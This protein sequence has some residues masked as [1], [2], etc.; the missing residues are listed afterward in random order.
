MSNYT[1]RAC[2]HHKISEIS[3]IYD[4]MFY[5][6]LYCS[7]H[8]ADF[9]SFFTPDFPLYIEKLAFYRIR[10]DTESMRAFHGGVTFFSRSK[11]EQS[12]SELRFTSSLLK[13]LLSRT[14]I[15][16]SAKQS[17]IDN[18]IKD[19]ITFSRWTYGDD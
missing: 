16:N 4:S 15:R 18:Q 10:S 19:Y 3:E 11:I 14:N 7:Q 12:R 2:F 8:F 9:L 5:K 1:F 6:L 13:I 17:K